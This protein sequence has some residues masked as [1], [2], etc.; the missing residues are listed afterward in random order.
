MPCLIS[1]GTGDIDF[2][3]QARR[4]ADQIPDAEFLSPAGRCRG[5][6]TDRHGPVGLPSTAL[7]ITASVSSR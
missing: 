1:L 3:D 7:A 2:L 6:T 4:A 5:D